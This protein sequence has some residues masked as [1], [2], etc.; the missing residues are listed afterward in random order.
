MQTMDSSL[1]AL[2]KNGYC[3]YEECLMRAVDKES[4]ARMVKGG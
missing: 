4:F 2:F 3:S 1:C